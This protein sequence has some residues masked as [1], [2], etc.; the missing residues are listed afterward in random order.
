MSRKPIIDA[1]PPPDV[2]GIPFSSLSGVSSYRELLGHPLVRDSFLTHGIA[3]VRGFGQRVHPR[4]HAL[5]EKHKAQG[6]LSFLDALDP[7]IARKSVRMKC[8]KSVLPPSR[9]PCPH[10][11][12]THTFPRALQPLHVPPRGP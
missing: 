11:P 8:V 1:S 9:P 7:S 2:P 12:H 3:V 5:A 4:V 6:L 10:P